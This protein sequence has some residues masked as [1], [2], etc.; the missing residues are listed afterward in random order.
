MV[1]RLPASEA[2]RDNA[3][4]AKID[5]LGLYGSESQPIPEKPMAE[6]RSAIATAAG[7]KSTRR[8]PDIVFSVAAARGKELDPNVAQVIRKVKKVRIAWYKR[9]QDR[10][11]YID[12]LKY[13]ISIKLPGTYHSEVDLSTL[14]AAPPP[15]SRGRSLWN[16][17][18]ERVGVPSPRLRRRAR[19]HG[20]GSKHGR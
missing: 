20:G 2:Q 17:A 18:W 14:L 7:P 10:E 5:G 15:G 16:H 8:S 6:L 3:I 13:Y 19:F 1:V 9:P 4:I 11:L 12:S